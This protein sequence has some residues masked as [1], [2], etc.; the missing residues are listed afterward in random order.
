MIPQ[1]L[2]T[3]IVQ[4]VFLAKKQIF[5]KFSKL[6][7][8]MLNHFVQNSRSFNNNLISNKKNAVNLNICDVS[9]FQ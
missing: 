5:Q 1:E 2:E 3:C 6:Y 8:L 7:D 9:I 4:Q